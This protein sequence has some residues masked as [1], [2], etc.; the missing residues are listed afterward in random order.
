[1][2]LDEDEY[3][4][5]IKLITVD[6]ARRKKVEVKLI[7]QDGEEVPFRDTIKQVL[8]YLDDKMTDSAE[9]NQILTQIMPLMHQSMMVGL[10]Q[11][12]GPHATTAI[13][14]LDSIRYPMSM[15][16]LLSF[17][18]LKL[19][20]QKNLKMKTIEEDISDEEWDKMSRLS[21]ATSAAVLGALHGY[22]PKQVLEE[23]V[24]LGEIN[25]EDLEEMIQGSKKDK[26]S[27]PFE[28]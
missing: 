23:L 22:Q 26:S 19:V 16:M 10:P 11:L 27:D 17:S 12:V 25:Q 14:S 5:A 9:A 3:M 20:Q 6:K 1:M 18:L 24:K 4:E 8:K 7:D 13:V 28:E 15:M 21:K 2:P